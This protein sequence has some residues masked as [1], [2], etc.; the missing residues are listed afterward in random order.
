MKE[1]SVSTL[2]K[3]IAP[4]ERPA[5]P[6]PGQQYRQI[7]VQLW[8]RGAYERELLDG[9]QTKYKVLFRVEK[10]DIIVNKIWARN[11]SVAVVPDSLAGCYASNEFPTFRPISDRLAPRWFHWLTKTPSFWGQC[12]EKSR[13]TSGKNRIRPEKFL[14][15]EIPLPS[16]PEQLRIVARIEELSV[17]IEEAH[18]LRERASDESEAFAASTVSKIFDIEPTGTLPSGWR[19]EMLPNLLEN[20]KSGMITGPFG[21]LLQ[22]SDIQASGVPVLGIANVQANLFVPGFT[23][24]VA[25]QKAAS[26]SAYKLR[27]EDIVIARSGTVG[28]A[29]LVP[30]CL[31]P[32][33]IMST[34]LIRLRLDQRRFLPR[35]LCMLFNGSRLI[36]KHKDSEC[37][38]SSRTFFT[39]KILSR[40]RLPIPPTS[41]QRRIVAY[42]DDLQAKVDIV[43]GLQEES[44]KELNALM[45]SI[46]SKAFAGEL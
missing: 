46:L 34:N 37:R 10:D 38:G 28:R 24:Y 31:D 13:G 3:I 18:T 5:A 1:F 17:K 12:D 9:G 25:H 11:G 30:G 45:P 39:Q 43:K 16:F 15:I 21:T 44:E 23:D 33:P 19:W 26:L 20:D 7:G 22:K 6:V 42:L 41:E 29:C 27:E 40:L 32:M 36:E 35:L 14:E 8:G 2:K 4:V